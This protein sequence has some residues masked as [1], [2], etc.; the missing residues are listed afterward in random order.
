MQLGLQALILRDDGMLRVPVLDAEQQE[1]TLKDLQH[2]YETAVARIE[3]GKPLHTVQEPRVYEKVFYASAERPLGRPWRVFE[4]RN[5][6]GSRFGYSHGKLIQ[7]STA[8][9]NHLSRLLRYRE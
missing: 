6:D 2:C 5:T 1:S 7:P 8:Y 9:E 4:L 3:H